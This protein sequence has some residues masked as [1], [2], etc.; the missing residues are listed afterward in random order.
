M[1]LENKY[2]PPKNLVQYYDVTNLVL[3]GHNSR[4]TVQ[5]YKSRIKRS[6]IEPAWISG[7]LR[8]A[9]GGMRGGQR[10]GFR[11]GQWGGRGRSPWRGPRHYPY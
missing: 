7:E 8:S 4:I 2:S 5:G 3:R 6:Q 10:G 9:R 11:R 1:S